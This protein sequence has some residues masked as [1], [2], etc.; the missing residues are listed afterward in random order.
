MNQVR[1]DFAML[2]EEH[3]HTCISNGANDL[4]IL[5]GRDSVNDLIYAWT[6]FTALKEFQQKIMDSCRKEKR[7]TLCTWRSPD[8]QENGMIVLG[9][10]SI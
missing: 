7:L 3:Q 9:E 10:V 4:F 8:N 5:D 6:H 1:D 2:L